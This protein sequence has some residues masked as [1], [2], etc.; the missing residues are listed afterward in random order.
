M[1]HHGRHKEERQPAG[2]GPLQQHALHSDGWAQERSRTEHR[3]IYRRIRQDPENRPHLESAP[4]SFDQA[5][6]F[7]IAGRGIMLVRTMDCAR[8]PNIDGLVSI[9]LLDVEP[10]PLIAVWRGNDL[11]PLGRKLVERI[12][13]CT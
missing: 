3:D 2:Q 9:P 13:A 11:C 12:P 10:M 1:G 5:Q 4:R 6:G 8:H 7:A